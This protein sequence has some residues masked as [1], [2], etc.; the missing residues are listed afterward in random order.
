MDWS[1]SFEQFLN[2][3]TESQ[4]QLFK[5][6]T[7][8][9]PGMQNTNT[10]SMRDSFDNALNFQEQVV[11]NS[12]EFQALLARLAIESQKQLWQN[13]FNMLRSK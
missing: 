6:W 13:Y 5:S 8:A 10:Q 11:N 4:R 9:M 7:A 2:Q 3:V 1:N 12:L